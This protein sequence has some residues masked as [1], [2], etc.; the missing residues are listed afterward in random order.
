MAKLTIHERRLAQLEKFNNEYIHDYEKAK[1]I[2]NVYYRYVALVQRVTTLENSDAYN[3][4]YCKSEQAKEEKRYDALCKILK[5]YGI[6]VFVP[7]S[8]PFLGIKD[9]TNG[10]IK[11]Q[12]IDPILY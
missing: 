1:Y 4:R 6:C 3:S 12:V 7:W 10:A 5:N 2:L 11:T 9:E 8:L